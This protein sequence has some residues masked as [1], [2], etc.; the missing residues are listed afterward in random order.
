MKT[1]FNYL[2]LSFLTIS[3]TKAQTISGNLFQLTN[4]EI[5]LE[6]FNGLNTYFISKTVINE[7]GEFELSYTTKDR[8][9]G[10]LMSADKKPLFVILS[11][12]DIQLQGDAF[13]ILESISITKGE[14]NKNFEQYALEQPKREQALSAW[15]YLQKM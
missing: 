2:F 1:L 7:K 14:Q 12:E 4:Q 8:G 15:G 3:V 5:R 13:S 11:G 9:V 6:G 10:Y